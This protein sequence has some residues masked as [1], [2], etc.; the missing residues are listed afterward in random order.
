MQKCHSAG[1]SCR[2]NGDVYTVPASRLPSHPTN[3]D[4]RATDSCFGLV[5]AHQSCLQ[6]EYAVTL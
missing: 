3:K 2:Q 5:G 1:K 6:L 4:G